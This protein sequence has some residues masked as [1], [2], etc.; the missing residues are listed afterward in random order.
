MKGGDK[1]DRAMAAMDDYIER[2]DLIRPSGA[3]PPTEDELQDRWY[4]IGLM[5]NPK[6]KPFPNV[7]NAMRIL[8][9]YPEF[10]GKI[11]YDEFLKRMLTTWG[12]PIGETKEWTDSFDTLLTALIQSQLGIDKMA[13]TTV[14]DAVAAVAFLNRR[15][16]CKEWLEGLKWDGTNR[17]ETMLIKGWGVADTP[18]TRAVARCWVVSIVAR[19]LNPGC[20]VD[21]VPTFEG[22][23][24]IRKSTALRTFAGTPWFTECH[25]DIFSKDFYGILDGK[26]IVE[27]AEM[28]A[29][30]RADVNRIKGIISCRIDRYRDPYG[31]R[32]T[33]HPRASTFAG[34]T[35]SKDWNRDETG[36]RR[37]WPIVAN[38]IDLAYIE[39]NR[40]QLFA[41]AV[42]RYK[43]NE[44]WWDVPQAEAE[45]E[46]KLRRRPDT[47]DEPI[48]DYT[49]GRLTLQMAE[50]LQTV[51]KIEPANQSRPDQMR[52]GDSLKFIGWYSDSKYSPIAGKTVRGW[53]SP[54]YIE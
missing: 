28:H 10:S 31:K 6:K 3:P 53:F 47:W 16:E 43:R 8:R 15:N 54:D 30:S 52:A 11:W 34:T 14:S 37:F 12:D 27:I 7:D 29:F 5:L 44:S 18:Y 41:E 49:I 39:A 19:V 17:L 46:Q 42:A 4:Q 2:S 35:N 1:I 24:G 51:F 40:E 26:M 23:Q 20:Q 50:L 9:Y 21:T 48:A 13:K 45:A 32:T 25:E 38:D 33:D 36:A 22:R